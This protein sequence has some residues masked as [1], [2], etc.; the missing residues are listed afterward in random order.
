MPWPLIARV[1]PL[2]TA[3]VSLGM[4]AAVPSSWDLS[5]IASSTRGCQENP[6]KPIWEQN[7]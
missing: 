4:V 3:G 6:G 1:V 2:D 5:G 7:K